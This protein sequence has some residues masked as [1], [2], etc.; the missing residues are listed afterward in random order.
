MTDQTSTSP[1][2]VALVVLNT[3]NAVVS[4]ESRFQL[5]L[6]AK[7]IDTTYFDERVANVVIPNINTLASS[8]RAKS[9]VVAWVRPEWRTHSAVDWPIGTRAGLIENG[10]DSPSH[11]GLESFSLLDG[12][13]AEPGDHL[14]ST[15]SPSAFCG[16]P[17][18]A[19]LR[20]L[21]V[22][23]VLFAGCFTDSAVVINAL[24]AMNT[25]FFPTVVDDA[26]ASLSE[27]RHRECFVVHSRLPVA[28]TSDIV[29]ELVKQP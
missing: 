4:P 28:L 21:Q 19:T 10:F 13:V 5:S 17:L 18:L 1:A 29:T 27:E 14:L 20:N 24:D 26:C 12:F 25:D 2:G 3:N 11:E 16:S 15:F 8:V 6:R 22:T 23:R 7:G 9:G